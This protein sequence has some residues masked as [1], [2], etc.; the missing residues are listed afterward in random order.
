MAWCSTIS[1]SV[2]PRTNLFSFLT[3]LTLVKNRVPFK[4]IK[5][6][7]F[8]L[9][10]LL[11]CCCLPVD[12][13]CCSPCPGCVE[14]LLE[15]TRFLGTFQ[16]HTWDWLIFLLYTLSPTNNI[17]CSPLIYIYVFRCVVSKGHHWKSSQVAPVIVNYVHHYYC[18]ITLTLI[19]LRESIANNFSS[20]NVLFQLSVRLAQIDNL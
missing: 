10:W 20:Y 14:W 5:L 4:I 3:T 7:H 15:R 6:N 2:E 1:I 19:N 12:C 9:A 11:S 17:N 18:I 8:C 13:P 16:P